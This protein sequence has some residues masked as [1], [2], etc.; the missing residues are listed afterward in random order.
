VC[1]APQVDGIDLYVSGP[2][3]SP[4]RDVRIAGCAARRNGSPQSSPYSGLMSVKAGSQSPS[5]HSPD[6]TRRCA[7][8][9]GVFRSPEFPGADESLMSSI[10][11][12]YGDVDLLTN[13]VATMRGLIGRGMAN[14]LL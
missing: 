8:F 7:R 9:L 13:L 4:A 11:Q 14:A 12:N 1:G 6:N 3:H 5:D 10:C 2:N